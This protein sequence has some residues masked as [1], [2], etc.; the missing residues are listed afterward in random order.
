ME[1]LKFD[2]LQ[3]GGYE[4][5]THFHAQNDNKYVREK[6][7]EILKTHSN[8][9]D[10]YSNI[11]QKNKT[12]P[13]LRNPIKFYSKMLSYLL[14]YV[15]SQQQLVN[16]KEIIIVAD[17]VPTTQNKSLLE[18]SIKFMLKEMLPFNIK[19]KILHHP[20]MSNHGL[21]IVDYYCYSLSKKYE[22]N[23]T[24]YYDYIKH[25]AKSEFDFFKTGATTY[26]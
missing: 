18:K 17:R 20:S 24:L 10:L 8:Q 19:Y 12:N 9:F 5:L 7:Y 16:Y 21:Q 23:E 6:V 15:I 4:H 2:L 22:L 25:R 1:N 11:I 26:Y 13:A 14:R 3:Y